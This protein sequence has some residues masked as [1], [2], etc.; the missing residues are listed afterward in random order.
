MLTLAGI[1]VHD[2]EDISIKTLNAVKTADVVYAEMYTS[3]PSSGLE[4]LEKI[5]GRKIKLLSRKEMED[6]AENIVKESID[7]NVLILIPGD[8]MV[9][10]THSA[11]LLEAKKAGVR[12]RVIHSS[13][14]SSAVCVT[15][16][17]FY[18]FGKTATVSYP[19]GSVVSS[20]PVNV[21]RQNW[22]INAHTLLLL[23][24]NPKP[25]KV[26]K[27]VDLLFQAGMDD[28]FAV[29]IGDIGGNNDMQCDRLS[30]LKNFRSDGLHSLI[31]LARTL[32]FMEFE[33][34]RAF[35]D[36]P[37]ELESIVE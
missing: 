30:K 4:E 16:L 13:S 36:A 15:G 18:R 26:A 29:A 22:S 20:H 10:T 23:D 24:L 28:W 34:L 25:M 19:L 17:H 1:G 11:L 9:A 12:T 8:P 31:V 35:A 33:C 2:A 21:V 6:C 7:R 3:I 37:E 32:H 27:A 14:I 5:V